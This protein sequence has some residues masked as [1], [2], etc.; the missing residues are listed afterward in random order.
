M[1]ALSSDGSS[2]FE[3]RASLDCLDEIDRRSILATKW[4]GDGVSRQIEGGNQAEFLV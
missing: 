4:S 2:Y 1:F 3:E